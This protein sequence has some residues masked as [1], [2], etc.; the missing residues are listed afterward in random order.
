MPDNCTL[1]NWKQMHRDHNHIFEFILWS[2]GASRGEKTMQETKL[3]AMWWGRIG[4]DSFT[5]FLCP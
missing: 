3:T 2:K 5:P 1:V 4:L